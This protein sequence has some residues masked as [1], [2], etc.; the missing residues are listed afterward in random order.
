M[1]EKNSAKKSEVRVGLVQMEMSA[2]RDEN[3][4]KAIAGIRDLAERGAQ[5]VCLSELFLSRYFCQSKD[6]SF[7]NL[8]EPIPGLSTDLLM[9]VAK[10]T[11]VVIIASLYEKFESKHFNTAVV[12]DAD[13]S[14]L[15]IYRKMHI[16]NDP[17]HG[18]GETYYFDAG[19]LGFKV[20]ETKFGRVAPMIC[21]DQWFPEGARIAASHGAQILFYP[22]AI[23][24]NEK[25]DPPAIQEAEHEAWQTVQRSHSIANNVF[26]VA[27]NR[28][29]KEDDLT[30]WG[31]SFVSDPYGRFIGKASVEKPENLLVTCDLNLIDSMRKDWPFMD[32]RRVRYD[33]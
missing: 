22:T 10:E 32:A 2:N 28:T 13:G 23:G 29:G 16:P 17:E 6:D 19:D 24:W 27:V 3:L 12:I 20:F 4:K 14:F 9:Q 31:T 21:W 26:T 18:Y 33:A 7:F 5:I 30:F 1:L 11:G 8:S 25:V 15:G